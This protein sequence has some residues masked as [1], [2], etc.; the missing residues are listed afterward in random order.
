MAS[1]LKAL[2]ER[3]AAL[4]IEADLEQGSE[5]NAPAASVQDQLRLALEEAAASGELFYAGIRWAIVGVSILGVSIGFGSLMAITAGSGEAPINVL[6]LIGLAMLL[7]AFTAGISA[8]LAIFFVRNGEAQKSSSLWMELLRSL[9]LRAINFAASGLE[10]SDPRYRKRL[11]AAQGALMGNYALIRPVI[12]WILLRV[13]QY[14]ALFIA[15]G[16]CLALLLRLATMDLTF[17]WH[18]TMGWVAEKLPEIIGFLAAPFSWIHPDLSVS[19][20]LVQASQFSRFRQVFVDDAY[21]VLHNNA[22]WPFLVTGVLFWGVLPRTII[23]L[24]AGY[25]ERREVRTILAETEPMHAIKERLRRLG[26][27]DALFESMG[28]EEGTDPLQELSRAAAKARS[29]IATSPTSPTITQPEQDQPAAF[30]YWEQDYAPPDNVLKRM[31]KLLGLTKIFEATWGNDADEDAQILQKID[32]LQPKTV[33][34]FVEPF[35]NPGSGFRRQIGELR[36]N[37]GKN[38]PIM[39]NIG[40]YAPDGSLRPQAENQVHIWDESIAALADRRTQRLQLPKN[41]E[42]I[43]PSIL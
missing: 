31:Q 20:T 12:P 28:E 5:H 32:G 4:N 33:I 30:L 7:P 25:R 39:I 14:F 8:V 29:A 2:F 40:W 37:V 26:Q 34:V 36:A 11:Q 23:L 1:G 22:W 3:V 13:S 6:W 27:K 21:A 9:I 18:T 17:G 43:D 38:T 35:A 24:W 41:D 19:E 16:F 10:K 42:P 15:L